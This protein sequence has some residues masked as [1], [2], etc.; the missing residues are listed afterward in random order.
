ME[1]QG[2]FLE[3]TLDMMCEVWVLNLDQDKQATC[4]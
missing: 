3:G 2:I 4:H 1:K